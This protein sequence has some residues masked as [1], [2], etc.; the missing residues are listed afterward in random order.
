MVPLH[1]LFPVLSVLIHGLELGLYSYSVF[2]QTSPDTLDP[3]HSNPGPPWYITKSCS[4]AVLK[5]NV[6]YC[7]QAKASFFVAVF[8]V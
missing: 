2:G 1:V 5:S 3:K 6:G 7:Q 4:V 8:M